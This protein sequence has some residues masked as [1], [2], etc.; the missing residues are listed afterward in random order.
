M[1][2]TKEQ[3]VSTVNGLE[4]PEPVHEVTLSS[5][6]IGQTEVTQKLWTA[7]MGY[8]PSYFINPQGP[9]ENMSWDECQEFISR[10][11]ELTGRHFRLPTEAEWEFAARGGN[12]SMHY[13]YSG[14]RYLN[15]VAWN[16][17]N[18]HNGQGG[19]L[20]GPQTV[21]LLLPNE[22]GLYDMSG[23][24]RELCHDWYAPYSAEPQTNP[25]GP[26]TGDKR[27]I[28][29][30]SFADDGNEC[31]CAGRRHTY[32]WPF[33]GGNLVGFRLAM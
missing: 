8:N 31:S 33:D 25:K 5:Y 15:E 20:Y 29:G 3:D 13:R 26:E 10:L 9:I 1:G 16:D 19:G 24:I 12:R 21:A 2:N 11:S 27:V 7:V 4:S 6:S 32:S 23:N 28:R 17:D 22:L 30:G 14:S 18:A